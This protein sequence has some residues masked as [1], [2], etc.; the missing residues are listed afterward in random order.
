MV[1]AACRVTLRLPDA[2]SLKD[3]RQ[4]LRGLL[5]RLRDRHNAS[6]VEL[7]GRDLW[8]TAVIGVALAA[9]D[10]GEAEAR[11]ERIKRDVEE[12]TRLK[13]VDFETE[14]H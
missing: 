14:F 8:Q 10:R 3:K 9:R 6:V 4:V 5:R 12:T 13:H 11:L 1:L 2:H 7:D